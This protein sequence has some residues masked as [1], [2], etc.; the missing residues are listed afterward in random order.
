MRLG[1]SLK[2]WLTYELKLPIAKVYH[3]PSSIEICGIIDEGML[4]SIITVKIPLNK[5]SWILDLEML[6]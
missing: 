5:I 6:D 2:T 4:S 1:P 3:I